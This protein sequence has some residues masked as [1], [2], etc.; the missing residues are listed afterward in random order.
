MEISMAQPPL[1]APCRG[2]PPQPWI[3]AGVTNRPIRVEMIKVI[4]GVSV[5]PTPRIIAVDMMKR[6]S[7]GM[8]MN[9]MRA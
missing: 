3:R 7:A 8:P 9:M 5:S 4:S 6:N 1:A 2:R